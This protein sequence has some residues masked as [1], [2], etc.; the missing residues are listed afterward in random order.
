MKRIY[1]AALLLA[2]V[3][4]GIWY[5]TINDASKTNYEENALPIEDSHL[6]DKP[7]GDADNAIVQYQDSIVLDAEK[8]EGSYS[9]TFLVSKDTRIPISTTI[10]IEFT[11]K[12]NTNGGYSIVSVDSAKAENNSGW[13]CVDSKATVD[14]DILYSNE[15]REA[16]IPI[17]YQASLGDG[18][19]PQECLIRLDLSKEQ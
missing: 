9:K 5:Y 4:L 6:E 2:V 19:R 1:F 14:G 13:T 8:C 12:S 18:L 17:S 15:R 10:T 7:S 3:I 11:Y 16:A